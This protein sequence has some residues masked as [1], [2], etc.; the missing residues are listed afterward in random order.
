M[1]AGTLWQLKAICKCAHTLQDDEGASVARS[2]LAP[3]TRVEGLGG[4]MKKAQPHP[5]AHRISH[6]AM[7]TVVVVLGELLSLNETLPHLS[8]NLVAVAEKRPR[9]LCPAVQLISRANLLVVVLDT[10]VIIHSICIYLNR[11][12]YL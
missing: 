12:N 3:R 2:K 6:R 5:V 9:S 8:K 4:A 11:W 1:D 10:L 7:M